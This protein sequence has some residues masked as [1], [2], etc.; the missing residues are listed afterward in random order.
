MRRTRH[1]AA[2]LAL[3]AVS[4]WVCL[5]GEKSDEGILREIKEVLWPRAYATQDVELLDSILADEFQMVD[6]AGNWTSKADEIEWV[7]RNAASYD[8]FVFNILRLD[9]FENGTAVVAGEGVIRGS[10]DE[11]DYVM[12]YQSSNILIKRDGAWRAV[13]SHVSGIDRQ[14]P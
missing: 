5:A 10:D 1:M 14:T 7:R 6:A 4:P 8:S 11:G 13:A 12:T 9:I 2:T 3:L